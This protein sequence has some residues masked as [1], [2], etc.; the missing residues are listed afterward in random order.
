M[1]KKNSNI[2]NTEYDYIMSNMKLFINYT[3]IFDFS[4]K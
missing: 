4:L 2:L 3:I 1:H